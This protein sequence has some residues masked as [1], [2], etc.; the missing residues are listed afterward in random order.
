MKKLFT[1]VVKHN[2]E[3]KDVYVCVDD[4]TAK[5]LA[6]VD[7]ATRKAYLQEEYEMITAENYH[8]RHTQSLDKSLEN[9]F[10]IVDE[11]Q[12]VEEIVAR[13]MT[14]E[15]I[16][17]AIEQLEPQQQ[18]LIEQV[19]YNE[20]TKVS[21]AEELGVSETAIRRRLGKIYEKIKKFLI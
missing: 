10:D 7:E 3:L 18:W 12:N 20:R 8:N 16:R 9:G 6:Q 13:E 1:Q 21:I 4:K 19:Y 2:G 11:R 15:R 14:N 5:V 17:K